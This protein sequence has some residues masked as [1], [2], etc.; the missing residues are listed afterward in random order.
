MSEKNLKQGAESIPETMLAK[1]G[2]ST[3]RFQQLTNILDKLLKDM[4]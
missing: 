3:E 4:P 1:T 2:L